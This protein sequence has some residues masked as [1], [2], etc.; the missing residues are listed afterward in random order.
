MSNG[1][2]V[3]ELGDGDSLVV[4]VT[5][6]GIVLDAYVVDA[7]GNDHL[8]GTRAMTADEWFGEVTK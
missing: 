6:E 4:N 5:D 8:L 7:D 2:T 1:V 3:F